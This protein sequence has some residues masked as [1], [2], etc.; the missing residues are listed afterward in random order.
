MTTA[1]FDLVETAVRTASMLGVVLGVLV[2]LLYW[3]KRFMR[4]KHAAG[5]GGVV[6]PVATYYFS[7]KE[8]IEVV[9]IGGDRIVVG[10]AAN[11]ISYLTTLVAPGRDAAHDDLES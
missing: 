1:Y 9:E 10:I 11:G 2:L 5:N 8:R 3:M 4:N 7:P 6:K